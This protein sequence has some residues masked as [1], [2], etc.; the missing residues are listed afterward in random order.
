MRQHEKLGH[1]DR[2]A[3]GGTTRA[4]SK[5]AGLVL[6]LAGKIEV[7]SSPGKSGGV[8]QRRL[9]RTPIWPP[10]FSRKNAGDSDKVFQESTD[11]DVMAMWSSGDT[12]L[13]SE[14]LGMVSPELPDARNLP[15][16]LNSNRSAQ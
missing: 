6:P 4:T 9:A 7:S 2:V 14:R 5:Y 8:N 11:F 3:L 10:W 13:N 16:V 1:F 12:I 15:S